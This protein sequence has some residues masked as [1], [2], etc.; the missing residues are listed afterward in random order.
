LT[1][2]V[3]R[4]TDAAAF[5]TVIAEMWD[6]WASRTPGATAMQRW[7]WVGA[8][9]DRVPRGMFVGL[10]LSG[11]DELPIAAAAF[12]RAGPGVLVPIG[13]GV[14]DYLDIAVSPD[15]PPTTIDHLIDAISE[16]APAVLFRQCHPHGPLGMAFRGAME[17]GEA[18]P[19][20]ALA[21][22]VEEQQ[23]AIPKRLRQ[24]LNYADRALRKQATEV[25][26]R[27][28]DKDSLTGDIDACIRLHQDRWRRRWMPGLF[29]G[30]AHKE[31][32]TDVS[33]RLLDAGLLRL[34]TLSV[35]DK[36]IA[37]IYCMTSGGTCIYYLGGFDQ[38]YHKWSPGM[39]ATRA[40]MLH[41]VSADMAH[42]FDFLR[43]NEPY[44]YRWGAIDRLN[45]R[46]LL[47]RG[48]YGTAICGMERHRF[49]LELKLKDKMHNLHAGKSAHARPE[50][51][52][53]KMN[54]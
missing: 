47:A 17:D 14:S 8:N 10:I 2:R 6:V 7:A 11:D 48:P 33:K 21:P 41:A 5:S 46:L 12:K 1:L 38:E 29:A 36:V 4:I 28:A 40:A 3:E 15:A 43:G 9:I 45:T 52:S 30:N 44:K 19:V 27:I 39:L 34:H 18:C 42:T 53:D 22:T 51:V 54:S 25:T 20:L 31:W 35:D 49:A 16:Q 37:A 23:L 24:N 32:F 26:Y 50:A 13:D